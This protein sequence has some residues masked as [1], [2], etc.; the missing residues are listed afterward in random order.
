MTKQEQ[1]LREIVQQSLATITQSASPYFYNIVNVHKAYNKA[2]D[3]IINYA[4]TNRVPV[5][6]AIAL[7]ESAMSE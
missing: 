3:M 2:E 7:I 5:S 1:Q 6:A 4:I